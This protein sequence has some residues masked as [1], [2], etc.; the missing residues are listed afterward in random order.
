MYI[1]ETERTFLRHLQVEDAEDLYSLN[2]DPDVI[3]YT[4]DR[5]FKSIRE[6]EY[7]LR[8]YDQHR[9]YGV[10]R[11]AVIEK[12]SNEFI[13][14][15]GLKYLEDQDIYDLGYRF[16]RRYWNKGFATESA[17]ACLDYG[18]REL[19]LDKITGRAMKENVASIKVLEKIGMIFKKE[20]HFDEHDG[21]LFEMTKSEYQQI[22]L[23]NK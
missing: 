6:A 8:N 18:F 1:I 10:G 22:Q 17:R 16:F 4:G 2:L 20:A 21:V 7:F 3:K 9:K 15:C 5:S 11:L 13:G 23:I 12:A 14:W 19:N